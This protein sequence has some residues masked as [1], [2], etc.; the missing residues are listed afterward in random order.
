VSRAPDSAVEQAGGRMPPVEVIWHEVE[1]G[2][3]RAD[4]PLWRELAAAAAPRG[5]HARVL[6]LGAGIG[7]VTLDL[8]AAGHEVTA[9]DI[10]PALLDELARRAAGLPVQTVVGDVRE[11]AL[12]QE[13]FDLGLVPMQTLQLLR[14]ED[15]RRALFA[16]AAAHL[17][18]GALLACAIVTDAEEFDGLAGQLA[19]SPDRLEVGER[20]YFSRPLRLL[21]LPD[22]FRIERERVAVPGD[23]EKPWRAEGER[24]VVDLARV[25]EAQLW[26]EAATAG[27]RREPTR[28][29]PETEEH[30]ASEVVMFRV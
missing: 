23:G 9:V 26:R 2:R 27:L 11:L 22:S 28:L 15:E 30:L 18:P 6:D 1:C 29:I 24:D 13:D 20:V 4:L 12:E 21:V 25:S 7:R 14:G 19:P 10:S 5:G 3:Y 8:A 16:G 17:R